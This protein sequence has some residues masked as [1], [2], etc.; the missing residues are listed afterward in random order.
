ML[1]QKLGAVR[2]L[3]QVLP[4]FSNRW[5]FANLNNYKV[6][7]LDNTPTPAAALLL[8]DTPGSI[9]YKP[10]GKRGLGASRTRLALEAQMTLSDGGVVYVE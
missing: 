8:L 4:R 5:R 7:V 2:I 9:C 10:K 3:A 1:K 6:G